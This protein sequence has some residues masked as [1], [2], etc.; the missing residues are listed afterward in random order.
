MLSFYFLSGIRR[1][2]CKGSSEGSVC[3]VKQVTFHPAQ[4]RHLN[5]NTEI[6]LSSLLQTS[7]DVLD[8]RRNYSCEFERNGRVRA[9]IRDCKRQISART[10]GIRSIILAWSDQDLDN[11]YDL[12]MENLKMA[13]LVTRNVGNPVCLPSTKR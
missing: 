3:S 12:R 2:T 11:A 13:Y 8:D 5:N 4:I 7:I 6:I 1:C 9:K 10:S